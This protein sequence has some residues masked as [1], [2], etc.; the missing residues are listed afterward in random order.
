MEQLK[1]I[2]ST[3]VSQVQTQLVDLKHT[4]PKELGEVIYMIKEVSPSY[5]LL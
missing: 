5:L 2:K 3:L 1:E 4:N